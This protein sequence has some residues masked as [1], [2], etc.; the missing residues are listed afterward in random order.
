MTTEAA[1]FTEIMNKR[2]KSAAQGYSEVLESHVDPETGAGVVL[3]K[4]RMRGGEMKAHFYK[5]RTH[6]NAWRSKKIESAHERLALLRTLQKLL[7]EEKRLKVAPHDLEA[8]DIIASI[9]GVTMQYVDFYRVVGAPKPR[10]VEMVKIACK[11][12][13]G[14]HMA[15][16]CVPD[17]DGP[18]AGEPGIF[19]V[20]MLSGAA[21]VNM[22][23]SIARAK[24]WN[25]KPVS[26]YSD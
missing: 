17:T 8:G 14:D 16:Q 26:I 12:V 10:K 6:R 5:P 15:G 4:S 13:S 20:S 7:A 1:T 18:D 3:T 11:M 2:R 23:S 25:G 24:K 9:W 19:D 22:R 21:E